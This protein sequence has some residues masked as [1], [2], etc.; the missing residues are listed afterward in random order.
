MNDDSKE[1][2]LSGCAEIAGYTPEKYQ[3]YISCV[4]Q[5]DAQT[6][7]FVTDLCQAAYDMGYIDGVLGESN[8]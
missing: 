7:K 5:I 6:V 4:K 1:I 3:Y 8:D 2:K